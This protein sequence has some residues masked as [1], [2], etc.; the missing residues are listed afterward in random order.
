MPAYRAIV[1]IPT[2]PLIFLLSSLVVEGD[3][4]ATAKHASVIQGLAST[5]VGG[6]VGGFVDG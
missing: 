1:P 6:D 4:V 2:D 3:K 5:L